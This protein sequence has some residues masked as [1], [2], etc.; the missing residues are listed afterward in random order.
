MVY[1]TSI[2]NTVGFQNW[3][4]IEKAVNLGAGQHLLKL[5]VDGDYLNLDKMVF[6]EIK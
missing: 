6:E 4:V 3:Q 1:T 2:P 5:V